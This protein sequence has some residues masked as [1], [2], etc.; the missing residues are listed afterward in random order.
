[1]NPQDLRY[2]LQRHQHLPDG[3]ASQQKPEITIV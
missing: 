1:L 2:E 3:K